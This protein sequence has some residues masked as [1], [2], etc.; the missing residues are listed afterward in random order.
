[1]VLVLLVFRVSSSYINALPL[2]LLAR[3]RWISDGMP[4]PNRLGYF[5]VRWPYYFGFGIIVEVLF[6]CLPF[7][8]GAGVTSAYF[9]MVSGDCLQE[10]SI[11]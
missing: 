3:Y 4:L 9:A 11:C 6:E 7:F 2:T 1:M 8:I 5:E 10:E